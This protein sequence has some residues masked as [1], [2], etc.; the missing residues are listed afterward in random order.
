MEIKCDLILL[1]WNNLAILE[2]CV[3]SLVRCTDVPSRLTIVD[4]GSTEEGL[5]EY[6]A[7][8]K[9]AKSVQVKVIFNRLN[10]GF[11]K[12]MNKGM[13]ESGSAYVCILNNDIVVTEGWLAEMIK[14]AERPHGKSHVKVVK[15]GL[16]T[17]K[18]ILWIGLALRTRRIRAWLRSLR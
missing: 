13:E 9:D 2:R 6:L 18:Y 14:V 15:D 7:A 1:S 3:E 11:A 16:V 17:L 8:L 4:N 5:R 10:E 12:G